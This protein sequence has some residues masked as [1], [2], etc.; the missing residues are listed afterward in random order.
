MYPA[1]AEK[2]YSIW[3][4]AYVGT[5][6]PGRISG[7]EYGHT[8]QIEKVYS[9]WTYKYI[10][11][12]LVG[13]SDGFPYAYEPQAEKVYSIWT[14]EYN[15]DTLVG[16]SEGFN[17]AHEPQ[18]EKVYSIWTY[19][20]NND[21]LVGKSDEFKHAHQAIKANLSTE[22]NKT[23]QEKL[24][25]S[26]VT[27]SDLEGQILTPDSVDYRVLDPQY[28]AAAPGAW[29]RHVEQFD[30][31]ID[32]QSL[33]LEPMIVFSADRYMSS[34]TAEYTY[35]EIILR[36]IDYQFYQDK[37]FEYHCLSNKSRLLHN[38]LNRVFIK[39]Q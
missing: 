10:N 18:A 39:T 33:P 24:L 21:T 15:N 23:N 7:F 12:T 8:P 36:S 22:F 14:Y 2:V 3:T 4:H 37:V 28:I 17:H 1:E 31:V 30:Q 9:I 6:L 19:E 20:Y 16:K 34:L 5:G 29:S 35:A 27:V 26:D 32:V 38:N 11:D 13:K 25:V